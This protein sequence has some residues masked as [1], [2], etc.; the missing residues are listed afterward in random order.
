MC[1]LYKISGANIMLF[2]ESTRT[3]P[4]THTLQIAMQWE[5]IETQ[6]AALLVEGE[7]SESIHWAR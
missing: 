7:E 1:K 5:K 6:L 4:I 2:L 3:E